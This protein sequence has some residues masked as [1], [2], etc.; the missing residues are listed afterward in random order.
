[1]RNVKIDLR[2]AA[3]EVE[4]MLA[5][6]M[7]LVAVNLDVIVSNTTP[8]TPRSIARPVPLSPNAVRGS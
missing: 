1:L 2:W 5:I 4:R 7:E 8:V 6:A 3:G